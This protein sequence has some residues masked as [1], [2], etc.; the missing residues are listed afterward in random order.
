[1]KVHTS[2]GQTSYCISTE[3]EPVSSAMTMTGP[4][5]LDHWHIKIGGNQVLGSR[6]L[7]TLRAAANQLDQLV[8]AY[9]DNKHAPDR[10]ATVPPPT[11]PRHA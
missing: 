6:Y 9:N 5:H 7:G 3:G 4:L 1:M 11:V 2:K 10:M 8:T